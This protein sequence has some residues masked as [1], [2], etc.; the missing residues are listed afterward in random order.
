VPPSRFNESELDELRALA[1][2]ARDHVEASTRAEAELLG[3][4]ATITA[5]FTTKLQGTSDRPVDEL[6]DDWIR[7][8]GWLTAYSER[9]K[10]ATPPP[11]PPLD[12][13]MG[14]LRR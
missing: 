1:S 8:L 10:A 14:V 4:M 11:V 3:D 9:C 5:W 2:K 12:D 13:I 7:L 6:S